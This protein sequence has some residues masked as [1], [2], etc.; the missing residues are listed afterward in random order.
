MEIL[1]SITTD[2][3]WDF[4]HSPYIVTGDFIVERNVTLTIEPR[5]E[6]RFDGSYTLIVKGTLIA[7]GKSMEQ[8]ITFTS[9]SILPEMKDWKGI[10]IDN[11]NDS[12]TI[13]RYVK[14]KY[15]EVALDVFSSLPQVTDCIIQEN[16]TGLHG[17]DMHST[18]SYNLVTDNV[19]GMIFEFKEFGEV[20]NNIITH[21]EVGIKTRNSLKVRLNNIFDNSGY[22]LEFKYFSQNRPQNVD[23]RHNWWGT[24]DVKQLEGRIYDK[25][26]DSKLG[27]VLYLP[28][29]I[30]MIKDAGPR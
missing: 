22:N 5:V 18:V 15:A 16:D 27:E 19:Y 21:N 3:N 7:D 25:Q 11:T 12:K 30:S 23:A 8:L 26:D 20:T 17:F 28:Y 10:R 24:T 14:I 13:L 4:A 1:G 2:T 9:N 6:V 29:E